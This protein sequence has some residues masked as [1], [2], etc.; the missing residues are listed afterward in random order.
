M[1][2]AIHLLF[3]VPRW[4]RAAID[5]DAGWWTAAG[6]VVGLTAAAGVF[7]YLRGRWAAEASEGIVR[8]LRD[9]LYDHLQRLPAA[10]FDRAETGDLV[11]RCSSDV[12]TVRVFMAAQI[13]EIARSSL[14][15]ILVLPELYALDVPLAW[16]SLVMFPPIF[17]FAIVFFGK[18]KRYFLQADEAEGKMTSVLQEN[19]TGI[20]VVRAFARQEFEQNK[21]GAANG[22]FR[23]TSFDL[24][25]VLALYWALSDVL[26]LGQL[27]GVLVY[28]SYRLAGDAITVGTLVAFLSYA[29]MVIWPVRHLGRLLADLGKAVVAIGRITEILAREEESRGGATDVPDALRVV[30]DGLTFTYHEGEPALRGLSLRVEPGETIA[31][32]GAPGAGKSTF[33]KLLLRL[34]D[35]DEGTLAL[36]GHDIRAMD[37]G[38]VRASIAAVLQEPFLYSKTIAANLRVGASESEDDALRTAAHAAGVHD[39]VEHFERGYDTP[40]GERGV[41]LSGGQRQRVALARALLKEAPLLILDDALSAVDTATESRIRAA[42]AERAGKRTTILIAHRL[43]TV[44]HADRLYVLEHGRVVQEGTHEELAGQSGP[45]QRLWSIQGALEEEIEARS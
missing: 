3:R 34:Y 25:K 40:V 2:A 11:Q 18:V 16:A 12:E 41:T 21:F 4:I 35:H 5:N 36:N 24:M 14:L 30:A 43:S 7:H 17:L 26:C 13:V 9:R 6:A 39:D 23:N 10:F 19:L 38:A 8:A 1:A 20:R 37:R 44:A 45:Y 31:L 33:I 32:L 42:L 22:K 29:G 15:L 28:G 27:G